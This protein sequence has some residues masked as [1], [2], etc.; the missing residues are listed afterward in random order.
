MDN[1][2]IDTY[3]HADYRVR[4]T[5][6]GWVS[7][8]VDAALPSTLHTLIGE[9]NWAFIT[10]WNP[11]SQPQ[12]RAQNH[13]AQHALLASLRRLP[14]TIAIR[15]GIGVGGAWREASLFVVGPNLA[16]I[17]ELA[18]QFQQNAYV[19]GLGLGYARLRLS[20]DRPPH[21]QAG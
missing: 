18:Q 8:H 19:H 11:G 16:D 6:G 10:A 14:R 20:S 15:P 3:R 13:A 17:D 9:R 5:R 7:I 1:S 4:L 21:G 12:P 2:L